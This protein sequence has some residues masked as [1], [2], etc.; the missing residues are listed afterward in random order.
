MTD[1][2]LLKD[3]SSGEERKNR[4]AAKATGEVEYSSPKEKAVKKRSLT[5]QAPES[6]WKKLF[7]R[8]PKKKATEVKKAKPQVKP[9]QDS[10]IEY[11][12]KGAK[13]VVMSQKEEPKEP[14]IKEHKVMPLLTPKEAKKEPE[15]IFTPV[16]PVKPVAKKVEPEVKEKAKITLPPA[17]PKSEK[18]GI[19]SRLFKKPKVKEAPQAVS[20]E[21]KPKTEKPKFVPKKEEPIKKPKPIIEENMPAGEKKIKEIIPAVEKPKKKKGQGFFSRLFKKPKVEKAPE[22]LPIAGKGKDDKKEEKKVKKDKGKDKEEDLEKAAKMTEAAELQ[23]GVVGVDLMPEELE[24]NLLLAKKRLIRLGFYS[25]GAVV[26]CVLVYVGLIFYESNIEQDVERVEAQIEQVKEEID[27]YRSI[28]SESISLRAKTSAIKDIIDTHVYWSNFFDKLEDH[29]INNVYYT[30]FGGDLNSG[31][32]NLKAQ[33][34][35]FLDVG[36]Q[37]LVFQNAGNFLSD[38]LI[39]SAI[40]SEEKLTTETGEE[41]TKQKVEFSITLDVLPSVFTYSSEEED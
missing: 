11:E 22:S 10:K 5:E 35:S 27:N 6:F 9:K 12:V 33:T 21:L 37:L 2:N 1:I 8:S 30:S 15:D 20:M 32:I 17:E 34:K 14:L 36:R 13:P 26:V 41:V 40:K 31:R 39:N 23:T 4:P 29:T 16:Q 19:F 38:V 18:S 3:T 24:A 28:Q 25:I 7:G